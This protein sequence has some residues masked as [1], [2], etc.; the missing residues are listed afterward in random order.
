VA[1]RGGAIFFARAT[2]AQ[3]ERKR[4]PYARVR[5]RPEGHLRGSGRRLAA[6]LSHSRSGARRS[7]ENKQRARRD[8]VAV[9]PDGFSLARAS[10][11]AGANQISFAVT[12]KEL[13]RLQRHHG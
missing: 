9:R 10:V 12:F 11:R 1:L 5:A 3:D 2:V 8:E 4:L 7:D 6:D 13:D